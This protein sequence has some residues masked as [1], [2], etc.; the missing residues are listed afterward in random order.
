MF[1]DKTIAALELKSDNK[2]TL[3]FVKLV[4]KMWN[5]LNIKS[6]DTALRLNDPDRA[7]FSDPNDERLIFLLRI[8]DMFKD[9]STNRRNQPD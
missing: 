8:A 5:I 1:N 9:M 4:T 3:K 7:K 6:C 2:G